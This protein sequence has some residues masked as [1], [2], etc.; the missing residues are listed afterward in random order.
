ME[1]LKDKIR[2]KKTDMPRNLTI[3]DESNKN[4]TQDADNQMSLQLK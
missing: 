2:T 4:A 3:I 1:Q